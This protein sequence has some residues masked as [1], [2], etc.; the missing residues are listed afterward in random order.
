MQK[1]VPHTL[2]LNNTNYCGFIN[3][4][5]HVCFYKLPELFPTMISGIMKKS[6]RTVNDFFIKHQ[7]ISLAKYMYM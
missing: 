2:L 4:K 7:F 1:P 3:C 6:S 5:E